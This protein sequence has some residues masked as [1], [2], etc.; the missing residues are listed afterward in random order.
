M[1]E[2]A[3]RAKVD[4][5]VRY[6][7][8]KA[9]SV[10]MVV[11][12]WDD[13]AINPV[14]VVVNAGAPQVISMTQVGTDYSSGTGGV[15]PVPRQGEA[16]WVGNITLTGLNPFGTPNPYTVS[17]S[18][19]AGEKNDTI[20]NLVCAPSNGTNHTIF[21]STC[22]NA[23]VAIRGPQFN[24]IEEPQATGLWSYI[25]GYAQS[26]YGIPV[27]AVVMVDD[28]N[29]YVDQMWADNTTGDRA[30]GDRMTN[31]AW[32]AVSAN[33]AESAL[34]YDYALNYMLALG[35]GSMNSVSQV[36]AEGERSLVWWGRNLDRIWCQHNLPF[37]PQYGDHEVCQDFGMDSNTTV[38]GSPTWG[39][40]MRTGVNASASD[41]GGVKARQAWAS[42]IDECWAKF[43]K[44]LQGDSI[45]SAD[46]DANHW[47]TTIGGVR[48]VVPDAMY[49]GDGLGN[50][51]SVMLGQDQITDLKA[52]INTS[53]PWR[54]L[55]VPFGGRNYTATLNPTSGFN[56][57]LYDLVQTEYDALFLGPGG[58][59]IN[60]DKTIVVA[61]DIHHMYSERYN[62]AGE[63]GLTWAMPGTVSGS[64]NVKVNPVDARDL[65]II[66][67]ADL[68]TGVGDTKSSWGFG[69]VQVDVIDD[70]CQ[71][72]VVNGK[73][74]TGFNIGIDLVF[75]N[76]GEIMPLTFTQAAQLSAAQAYVLDGTERLGLDVDDPLNPGTPQRYGKSSLQ[77]QQLFA[78]LGNTIEIAPGSDIART[79]VLLARTDLAMAPS[80]ETNMSLVGLGKA[81]LSS[82]RITVHWHR[83]TANNIL[84]LGASVGSGPTR[85]ASSTRWT[86]ELQGYGVIDITF[87]N[88]TTMITSIQAGPGAVDVQTMVTK[89]GVYDEDTFIG[90]YMY[91]LSDTDS[92]NTIVD[93]VT[94][95][96]I[97]GIP[98]QTPVGLSLFPSLKAGW[99][100]SILSTAKAWP[101]AKLT[102]TIL[103]AGAADEG[104]FSVINGSAVRTN[105]IPSAADNL[106]G[107]WPPIAGT[108]DMLMISISPPNTQET[109]FTIGN[110][111]A[112]GVSLRE[113]AESTSFIR[114]GAEVTN[115]AT[116]PTGDVVL[117]AA[118]VGGTGTTTLNQYKHVNTDG[119][120]FD[121]AFTGGVN[122]FTT[123]A[124]PWDPTYQANDL[125]QYLGIYY[126]EFDNGI[127]GDV[128]EALQYMAANPSFGPYPGWHAVS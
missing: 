67:D 86:S 9:S 70:A 47:A 11:C 127:P 76:G 22:D 31:E 49:N 128:D 46:A 33:G 95:E 124:N 51:M 60:A 7:N 42:A 58:V 105:G 74:T 64:S 34:A 2:Q 40:G 88:P 12:T 78:D 5:G 53:D 75:P 43:M 104:S 122:K 123:F 32:D 94:V 73:A 19:G 37:L 71:A 77:L 111:T 55:A 103:T 59:C 3:L 82:W 15:T 112:N 119:T 125:D 14:T 69:V 8:P 48:I 30:T 1:T 38:G 106:I 28:V 115:F 92:D 44:P 100:P 41:P 98:Q 114:N 96:Q 36:G 126:Y 4:L 116:S 87:P 16:G 117:T 21:I 102:G 110:I 120:V 63:N 65:S 56:W 10:V 121:A 93:S 72:Y 6:G 66:Y 97:N 99:L 81:G 24:R 20:G 83:D 79:Q 84:E 107:T 17:Q 118:I 108:K 54:I 39:G 35:M 23:L 62:A 57:P 50:S 90:S 26:Q 18:G 80:G 109:V 27:S 25:R 113:A 29:G 13:P 52:A 45:A 91:D 68:W 89:T 85:F 101:A 61:G